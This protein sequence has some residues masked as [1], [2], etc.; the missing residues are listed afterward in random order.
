MGQ[1]LTAPR[2]FGPSRSTADGWSIGGM[3]ELRP[4][5]GLPD[6]VDA[7]RVFVVEGEKAAEAA[8]SIGLLQ[9][10][11]PTAARAQAKLTGRRWQER[12]ASYCPTTM[13]LGELM[14]MMWQRSYRS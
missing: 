14:H 1:D 4:L 6:L 5:Y 8:R 9:P 3:P 10:H 12:I 7:D 2:R 11:R 13:S